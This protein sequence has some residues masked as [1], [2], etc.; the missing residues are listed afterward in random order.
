[1]EEIE[2]FNNLGFDSNPFQFT[3]ADYEERLKN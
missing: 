1:M 2:F 3:N